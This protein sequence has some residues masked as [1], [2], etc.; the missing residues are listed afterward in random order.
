M[1][2]PEAFP[3]DASSSEEPSP[4]E[5][6]PL[7]YSNYPQ[8]TPEKIPWIDQI[9]MMWSL[10]KYF[11]PYIPIAGLLL[12][13]AI[14]QVNL[15]VLGA[16]AGQDA[17]QR[18]SGEAP[19][20]QGGSFHWVVEFL[21]IQDGRDGVIAVGVLM[22]VFLLLATVID[23]GLEQIRLLISHRFKESVQRDLLASLTREKAADRGQRDLGQTNIAF[24]SDSGEL[25]ST[26]IFG[27]LGALEAIIKLV[28]YAFAFFA[29]P[30]GGIL[31][32]IFL[33]FYMLWGTMM[34]FL[35]LRAE[36]KINF[37][38]ESLY[39]RS[40]SLSVQF[41][42]LV[43]RLIGMGG[44]KRESVR[45]MD[46]VVKQAS[47]NRNFMLFGRLR[48]T[49]TELP[50]LLS[51]ALVIMVGLAVH[52]YKAG[53]LIKIQT[54]FLQVGGLM[55]LLLSLPGMLLQAGPALKRVIG[56][57]SIPE[58]SEQPAQ[59]KELKGMSKAPRIAFKDASFSYTPEGPLI[60]DEMNLEISAGAQVGIVGE[61]GCGKSTVARLLLG[62]FFLSKGKL[63]L[64]DVEVTDW[65]V[66]WRRELVGFL[67]DSPGFLQATIREN[68]IFGRDEKG[69]NQIDSA[70]QRSGA[71][72]LVK[73]RGSSGGLECLL[74]DPQNQLSGGQRKMLGIARLLLGQQKILVFD[75]PEAQVSQNLLSQVAESVKSAGDGHTSIIITHR[76]EIFETDFNVFLVDGKIFKVGPHEEMLKTCPEYRDFMWQAKE[77]IKDGEQS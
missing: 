59:L 73:S 44:E 10:R 22:A 43:G 12:F 8:G 68:L 6:I 9:K 19:G 36:A 24:M 7:G 65:E 5:E 31:F 51:A 16:S 53:E 38:Q 71:D 45:L 69:L 14:F 18:L 26:L 32:F 21:A 55:S 1:N 66:Q 46:T 37:A 33:G 74:H 60:L 57:L 41:F 75:E 64:E 27:L 56:I 49:A 30:G 76:P 34:N 11:L 23:I 39:E 2:E 42:Q 15:N 3:P 20:Y 50:V 54:L 48:M 4:P 62:E 63:F 40:Q 70:L 58:L 67:P 77:E 61:A 72:Q 25:G 29:L 47:G 52:S 17:V 13:I 35:F 28:T